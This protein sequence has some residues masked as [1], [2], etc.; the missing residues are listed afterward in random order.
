[1]SN[2]SLK[3]SLAALSLVV[4]TLVPQAAWALQPL[5][6]LVAS[7]KTRNLDNREAQA[8][9][10]QR[11][12]EA[13]QSWSRIA[14]S[15]TAKA[16][17][18][19]NQYP[20]QINQCAGLSTQA[21]VCSDGSAPFVI[22]IT[23]VD[24]LEAVFT[25]N[26][27]LV[28]VGN[29]QRIG[30]ARATADAARLRLGA[31]ANDV[32]KAVTRTYFQVVG[33]EA[34]LA[35]AQRALAASLDS[36]KIVLTRKEAGSASDLDVERAR[37]EVERAKQVVAA[38]DQGRAVS[39]RSLESLTGVSPSEGSAALPDD[40]L[41]EEPG[42]AA[43]EPAAMGQPAVRAAAA[44]AKAADKTA[45]AGY[46]A[47]YPSVAGNVTERLT[48]ATG[49]SGHVASWA[50][51]VSAT[52]SL[53][54]STYFAAK[55]LSGASAVA[56]VR[57]ARAEQ[58]ARDDLHTEWQE[59]R[60]DVAKLKAAR[61]ESDASLRAAALA[62]DRYRAGSATQLE[63]VQAD[64]DAFAGEVA[65]IQAQADLAYA[66][67]AIRIDTARPRAGNQAPSAAPEE[68]R[69][70]AQDAVVARAAGKEKVQ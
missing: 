46:A 55:A 66:R 68:T 49:F 11:A 56:E 43:L 3:V 62:K 37:A 40:S 69:R 27:P 10:D 44:E 63:V 24:Q 48:N 59:V 29:W 8:V 61:A 50:V 34:T 36:Q 35:A 51:G 17:Y 31:S 21:S 14:P 6:E 9:V 12:S 39:R 20:A 28:D 23:P 65:R 30:A 13:K 60:A 64:R 45:D 53:D 25:L 22:S 67:A 26:V 54:L 4:P 38:A 16:T 19:R 41:A 47:L 32:E 2:G 58:Q 70:K 5:E 7:A 52:W 42:L 57:R 33:N 1:M 18:T 15:I